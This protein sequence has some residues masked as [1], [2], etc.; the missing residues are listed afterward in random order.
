MHEWMWTALRGAKELNPNV[1]LP[2]R[3]VA[4]LKL[5]TKDT[6]N[7][8]NSMVGYKLYFALTGC[9]PARQHYRWCTPHARKS[10]GQ[11]LCPFC[12]SGT[13]EWMDTHKESIPTSELS[14]MCML[15]ALQLDT[16]VC[17]QVMLPFW[18]APV[19][20]AFHGGK[21]V[22]QAD[23]SCH[24]KSMYDNTSGKQLLED[25]RFCVQAV[26]S[27]T[28]VIRVHEAQVSR[29]KRHKFMSAAIAAAT[30]G[31]CIVLSPGYQSIT[32]Y[33]PGRQV[34]YAQLLSHSLPGCVTMV[35]AEHNTIIRLQ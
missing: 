21:L 15:A 3:Q 25:V 5:P 34:T 27:G 18:G 13:D 32:M 16:R 22:I 24:F 28:S 29:P 19:A 11:L 6:I 31:V 35:D 30:N 12:M 8:S 33:E 9:R 10:A 2:H 23:G 14:I 4:K 17:W 26:T 7:I 20:F 1:V